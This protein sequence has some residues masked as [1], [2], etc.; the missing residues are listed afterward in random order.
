[1]EYK[2][3]SLA[4][5]SMKDNNKSEEEEKLKSL[6]LEV[7]NFYNLESRI[8]KNCFSNEGRYGKS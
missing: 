7:K 6:E 8:E 5:L 4:R 2:F 1:L 3:D